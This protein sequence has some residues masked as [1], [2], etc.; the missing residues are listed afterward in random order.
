MNK[1]KRHHR[2]NTIVSLSTTRRIYFVFVFVIL[3]F[4]IAIAKLFQI[5]VFGFSKY[6]KLAYE[7]HW[8]KVITPASRG[9]VLVRDIG[10]SYYALATNETLG[11]VY[12]DPTQVEDAPKTA[13]QLA[14][15]LFEDTCEKDGKPKSQFCT[16]PSNENEEDLFLLEDESSTL[17]EGGEII[18]ED[19]SPEEEA[20]EAETTPEQRK[21]EFAH[22]IMEAISRK[23]RERV[24]LMYNPPTE[25]IN[26]VTEWGI[27]GLEA[28]KKYL[29]A[30]PTKIKN[31]KL[32][33]EKLSP[34]LE[35]KPKQIAKTISPSLNKY[36][37]IANKLNLEVGKKIEALDLKGV[38]IIK[39]EWRVYPEESLAAHTLG[40]VDGS[41]K[42]RYGIEERYDPE[43]SGEAGVV[44][45]EKD[46]M[47]RQSSFGEMEVKPVKHGD[48]I[49]LSIDRVIQYEVE[50]RLKDAIKKYKADSG[51]IIIME[52][53]SGETTAVASYPTF[54]PNK[55]TEVY[56]RTEIDKNFITERQKNW[57]DFPF[58]KGKDGKFFVYKNIY[59]PGA[60]KNP[61]FTNLYEP[62]SVFKVITMASAVDAREVEP[63]TIYMDRAPIEVDMGK[64]QKEHYIKNSDGLYRGRI[65]MIDVLKWSSNTGISF[66]ARKLG[67]ELFYTYIKNFGFADFTNV[68]YSNEESGKIKYYQQWSEVELYTYG[69]GQGFSATPIQVVSAVSTIANGGLLMKPR[70]VHAFRS[71]SDKI[72][73]QKPKVVRRVISEETAEN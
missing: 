44:A 47:G 20:V 61:C 35:L 41:K 54:N 58:I 69:F 13:G 23:Y 36:V 27:M 5:Q 40:F 29:Y 8:G 14:S 24:L 9:E 50:K 16:K 72:T 34:Y 52:P 30:Y 43:L 42:A 60:Y 28:N 49:I 68:D 70:L 46:P 66:V 19:V 51:Q 56:E 65:N 38:R 59:G 6:S 37:P 1:K 15:I 73:M 33:A 31:P 12:V 45:G 21:E 10:K 11:L 2:T 3:I 71:P 32:A 4:S 63:K 62:G 48:D 22:K 17:E 53:F 7:R 26:K 57:Q 67:R 39:E 18:M 55:F 25:L 64:H